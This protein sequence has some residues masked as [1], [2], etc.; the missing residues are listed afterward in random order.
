MIKNIL[1]ISFLMLSMISCSN[2]KILDPNERDVEVQ[3]ITTVENNSEIYRYVSKDVTSIIKFRLKD[4][5]ND[6][7]NIWCL[8]LYDGKTYFTSCDLYMNKY[9]FSILFDRY[10]YKK[11]KNIS[12][13]FSNTMLEV[14]FSVTNI[15]VN[16]SQLT[17]T[18]DKQINGSN[19]TTIDFGTDLDTIMNSIKTYSYL[20][21][22]ENYNFKIVI[23]TILIYASLQANGIIPVS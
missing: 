20:S 4:F 9:Q 23:L 3:Y 2:V 11:I 19:T 14:V 8:E 22:K 15:S 13:L 10:D 18:F 12:Y 21:D 1:L 6:F 16:G 17:L 7:T 5:A